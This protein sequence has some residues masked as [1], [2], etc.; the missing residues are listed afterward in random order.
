VSHLAILTTLTGCALVAYA[1]CVLR[2]AGPVPPHWQPDT[3]CASQVESPPSPVYKSIAELMYPLGLKCFISLCT[4]PVSILSV[5]ISNRPLK[6][7]PIN[8][9]NA[10]FV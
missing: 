7:L 8:R 4:N 9:L 3:E 10:T 2:D 5:P 6:P 1:G